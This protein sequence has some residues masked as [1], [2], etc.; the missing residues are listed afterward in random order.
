MNEQAAS[1]RVAPVGVVVAVAVVIAW[2]FLAGPL[3]WSAAGVALRCAVGDDLAC[4]VDALDDEG[5]AERGPERTAPPPVDDETESERVPAE[6]ERVPFEDPV[7]RAAEAACEHAEVLETD[8][9]ALANS[10]DE[11]APSDRQWLLD[12]ARE[13]RDRA[14]ELGYPC[15]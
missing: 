7:A 4:L 13:S 10:P 11:A 15:R 9:D 3:R 1:G 6:S 14:A 2:A 5:G 8:A 12:G